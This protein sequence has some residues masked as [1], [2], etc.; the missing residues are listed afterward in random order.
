MHNEGFLPAGYRPRR[1]LFRGREGEEIYGHIDSPRSLL[2]LI[3]Y[4]YRLYMI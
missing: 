4:Q 3:C 2:F 1:V